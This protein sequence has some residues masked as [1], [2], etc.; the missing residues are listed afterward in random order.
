MGDDVITAY[1]SGI[2]FLPLCIMYM[3]LCPEGSEGASYAMLTTFSNISIG[4]FYIIKY[5]YI[6]LIKNIN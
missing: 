1:I 6:I 2:Q 4:K 5:M 3:H